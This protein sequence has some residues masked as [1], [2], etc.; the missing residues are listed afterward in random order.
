[1]AQLLIGPTSSSVLKFYSK[2]DPTKRIK[3]EIVV[4]DEIFSNDILRRI[5]TPDIREH[6]KLKKMKSLLEK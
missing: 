3:R 4:E 5:V 2:I 1:M 6:L